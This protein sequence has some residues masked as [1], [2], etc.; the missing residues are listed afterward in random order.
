MK[1]KDDFFLLVEKLKNN[2]NFAYTRF[3]DGEIA[4]MQNKKLLLESDHV[5]LGQTHHNFGYTKNDHKNFDPENDSHQKL[6]KKL[7]EAYKHKDKNYFVGSICKNCNCAST[8]FKDWMINEY[9]ALDDNYTFANLLVNSNYPL[10]VN[11]F[12]A[13]LKDKKVVVVCNKSA[14]C[15]NLPFQLIKDFRVGENCI[16]NDWHLIDEMKSYIADNNI[17]DTIFLF[18]A[19]S[20]SEVL[21]YELYKEFTNNTYI[22]IG[23]TLHRHLGMELARDYLRAYWKGNMHFDLIRECNG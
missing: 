11:H 12:I 9:G 4:I 8:E 1:F 16:I 23:T 20:L 7:L 18:S 15:S 22:D 14:D 17:K 3:S 2:E 13:A 5:I 19:S 10:F 6:R 21:I